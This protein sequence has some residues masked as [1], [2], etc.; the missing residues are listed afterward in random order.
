MEVSPF[1]LFYL[2]N[3]Y[4][5]YNRRE[6]KCTFIFSSLSNKNIKTNI[7]DSSTKTKKRK[8][9]KH[10]VEVRVYSYFNFTKID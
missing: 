8:N 9:L 1:D 3:T 2:M 7:S 4:R 6:L 10:Q 5:S